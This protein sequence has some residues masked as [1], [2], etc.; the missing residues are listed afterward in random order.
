[1]QE[2]GNLLR[3]LHVVEVAAAGFSHAGDEVLVKVGADAERA[4]GDP[5]EGEFAHVVEDLFVV[6]ESFVGEAIGEQKDSL[7]TG[8]YVG[9]D[10]LGAGEPASEEVGVGAC[11]E[12]ID[13]REETCSLESVNFSH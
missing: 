1:V 12:L 3:A 13:C 2:V 9:A 5:A 10:L 4:G 8:A 7:D 6:G 11:I